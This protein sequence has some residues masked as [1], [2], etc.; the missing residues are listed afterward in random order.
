VEKTKGLDLTQA[1]G[2]ISLGQA[3]QTFTALEQA[4]SDYRNALAALDDLVAAPRPRKRT[5]RGSAETE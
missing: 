5:G 4:F 2:Q 1:D 3:M